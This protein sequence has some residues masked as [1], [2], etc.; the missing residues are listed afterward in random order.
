VGETVGKDRN[1]IGIDGDDFSEQVF[2]G[3]VCRMHVCSNKFTAQHYHTT[4]PGRQS[5][6]H[7]ETN[8]GLPP[9]KRP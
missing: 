5:V 3:P 1:G 8:A 9:R 6:Y 4:Q 7:Q 2:V